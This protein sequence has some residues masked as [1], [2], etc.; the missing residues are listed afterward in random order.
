MASSFRIPPQR[1][2]AFEQTPSWFSETAEKL[3]GSSG[4]VWNTIVADVKPENATFDNVILPV[5]HNENTRLSDERILR[6]A[7]STS[8]EKEVRGASRNASRLLSH[9]GLSQYMRSDMFRLVDAVMQRREAHDLS[10]ESRHY[11]EKHHRKFIQNGVALNDAGRAQFEKAEKRIQELLQD[12]IKTLNEN[13]SGL[14]MY[15]EELDGLSDDVI[16]RLKKG[17]GDD[18]G[19]LWVS[20]KATDTSPIYTFAKR[21]ETRKKIFYAVQN[22]AMANIPIHREILLLR[23]ENARLLGYPNHAAYKTADKMVKNPETVNSFL[24][25]LRHQLYPRGQEEIAELTELK[26]NE[27]NANGQK[28]D[29]NLYLWDNLYYGRIR[30]ETTNSYDLKKVNE[31][32]PL[33]RVMPKMMEIYEH[34]FSIKFDYTPLERRD[35][36]F[37]ELGNSMSWQED[38]RTYTVWDNGPEKSFLGYLY[39]DLFPRDGKTTHGGHYYLQPGYK[40]PDGTRHYPASAIVTNFDRPTATSP[41]LMKQGEMRHLFH[42]LGHGLH[43][44]LSTTEYARFHGTNVDVDFGEAPAM[45]FENF[46]WTTRHMKDISCHYSHMSPEYSKIW[47]ASLAKSESMGNVELPP[48][49]ISDEIIESL[50]RTKSNNSALTNLDKLHGAIYD[51]T[52]Y[53][54]STHEELETMNFTEI[55]NRLRF[56][57]TGLKGGEALG[58]GWEWGH[59]NARFRA[60][61][62]KYSAGYYTYLLAQVWSFDIFHHGFKADTMSKEA[63]NRYRYTLLQPGGSQDEM[64]T[65]E[66]YLGRK[67]NNKAF[68]QEFGIE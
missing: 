59:G 25:D 48:E 50:I 55:F 49:K 23:D 66:N 6:F 31:Y 56:E 44:L 21:S 61:M 9:D 38:V 13:D 45:M 35:E 33:D 42:E 62:G 43:C 8:P 40:K 1:P 16:H 58:E 11:L 51:M 41:G 4:K 28:V 7:E 2:P 68:C 29:D 52:V 22:M 20:L 65:L 34:I 67:P 63:G 57:I 17:E 36:F 53:T 60:P 26:K 15:P 47:R 3:I 27:L 64:K 30:S 12:Y 39:F 5:I 24:A 37:G 10:P 18:V 54:P 46:L 14:W 19:K 32:F